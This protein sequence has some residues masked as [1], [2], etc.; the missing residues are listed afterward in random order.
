MPP[1]IL[2]WDDSLDFGF[3][4]LSLCHFPV[5]QREQAGASSKQFR[6]PAG[7]RISYR[8]SNLTNLQIGMSQQIFC[9][10]HAALLYILC[11]RAAIDLLEAAFEFCRTHAGDLCQTFY[12]YFTSIMITQIGR[13]GLNPFQILRSQFVI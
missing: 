10:T 8:L 5:L 7:C 2:F 4:S 9:L 6:K 1:H 12:G 11:D 3:V 13:Y